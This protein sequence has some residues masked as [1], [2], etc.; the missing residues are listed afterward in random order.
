MVRE[1]CGAAAPSPAQATNDPLAQSYQPKHHVP[2][3]DAPS[4]EREA[5]PQSA[6]SQFP[7]LRRLSSIPPPLC[8]H[9]GNKAHT[10]PHRRLL[11]W[12]VGVE[13]DRRWKIEPHHMLEHCPIERRELVLVQ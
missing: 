8:Y 10:R 2:I 4:L 12:A 3:G 7:E 6:F 11:L 5:T 1:L 13:A 9:V